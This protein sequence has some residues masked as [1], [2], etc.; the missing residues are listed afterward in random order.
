M[1]LDY[2][3]TFYYVALSKNFTKAAELLG[4]NQPNVTR[5]MNNLEAELGCR[6]FARSNRG[7][8]LTP[9]GEQ[10]FQYVSAAMNN[11]EQGEEEIKKTLNIE[12]GLV[13]IGSSETALRLM[14]LERLGSFHEEHPKIHFRISSYSTPQTIQALKEGKIDFAVISTPVDIKKPLHKTP[15]MTFQD[16]LIG[17]SKYRE[18]ASK[19]RSLNELM[20]YPFVSLPPETGTRMFYTQYFMNQHLSFHP[21]IEVAATDQ[22]RLMV[23]Y[24]LGIG[25]LPGMTWQQITL[26]GEE[27]C[28]IHLQEEIPKRQICLVTD[29]SKVLSSA[30]RKLRDALAADASYRPFFCDC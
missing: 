24:N 2:Y 3:K 25:F 16:V 7:V 23:R 9:I 29:E 18:L 22:I 14:L 1:N 12:N 20:S 11:L 27:V 30:A 5:S 8:S 28:Q 6:L 17:G 21:E 4:N 15:L 13:T 10:L 19:T 26:Q